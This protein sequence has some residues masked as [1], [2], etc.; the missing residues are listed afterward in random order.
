VSNPALIAVFVELFL[1]A[2]SARCPR[3]PGPELVPDL[4]ETARLVFEG[5]NTFRREKSQP[6]LKNDPRLTAAAQGF[7]E[8]MTRTDKYGHDADG[9]QPAERA[10]RH[11][12]DFCIVTENIAYEYNSAGYTTGALARVFLDGW[13]KSPGHRKNMLDPDVKDAGMAVAH[14]EKSGKYYGVCV[15][16]RLKSAAIEFRIVNEAGAKVEYHLGDETLTLEPRYTRTHQVCRPTELK[17]TW[18]ET[19]GK[20]ESFR[21][22]QGDRFVITKEQGK[23][24]AIKRSAGQQE[25]GQALP[26]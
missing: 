3:A 9:S 2:T 13:K 15:F 23:L 8:F 22:G 17:F 5:T 25:S 26:R 21:T 18:P 6:E 1:T 4:T 14:S 24:R 10:K 11:D 12:Y 20:A 7:A 16:G 19:E